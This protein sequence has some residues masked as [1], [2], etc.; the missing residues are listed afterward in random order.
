MKIIKPKRKCYSIMFPLDMKKSVKSVC[1]IIKNKQAWYHYPPQKPYQCDSDFGKR[2]KNYLVQGDMVFLPDNNVYYDELDEIV[3]NQMTTIQ[4]QIYHCIYS[5]NVCGYIR[6][7]HIRKLLSY[8]CLSKWI[9][10]FI[11][12]QTER[13]I[14]Q[15]TAIICF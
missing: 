12:V 8:E 10:P 2:R 13:Y 4:K 1:D 5:L 7:K 9:I 15:I 14:T 11:F 6:E 3:F